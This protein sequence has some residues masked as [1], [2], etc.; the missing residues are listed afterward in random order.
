MLAFIIFFSYLCIVEILVRA[1]KDEG[2]G[3][4]LESGVN[5]TRNTII[6][7]MDKNYIRKT[8]AAGMR[9]PSARCGLL[10]MG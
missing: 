2:A 4:R 8:E 5:R 9:R 1:L 3:L 7:I 6:D 10:Y